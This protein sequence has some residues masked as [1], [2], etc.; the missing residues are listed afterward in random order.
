MQRRLRARSIG[1]CEISSDC[2]DN[3]ERPRR[4]APTFT[5]EE[6][7]SLDVNVGVALRG[8]PSLSSTITQFRFTREEVRPGEVG[9]GFYLRAIHVINFNLTESRLY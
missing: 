9:V 7:N 5:P 1:F 2:C 8:H 6:S 3:H 4:A